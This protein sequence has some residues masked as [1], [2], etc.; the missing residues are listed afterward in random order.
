MSGIAKAALAAALLN[1]GLLSA[2]AENSS[3]NP[4]GAWLKDG[5]CALFG[6]DA[7]PGDR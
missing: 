2:S 6:A 5:A 3:N 4:A 1:C 7:M